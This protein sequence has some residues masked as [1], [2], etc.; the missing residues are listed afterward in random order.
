V[1]VDVDLA[2]ID[3]GTGELDSEAAGKPWFDTPA[4]PTARFVSDSVK[5]LGGNRYAVAGKLTIKG[6]TR[7]VMVPASFT[8]QGAAGV[9]DG[10][11]TLKRGEFAIGEGA[12]AAFDVVANDV[13]VR[14]RITATAR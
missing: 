1:A 7:D 5:P 13:Q 9:F 10:S 3:T 4:F 2:S 11:F 12:W 8:P 14:F 6:R